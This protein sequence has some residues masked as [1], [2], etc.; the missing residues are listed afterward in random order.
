MTK[1]VVLLAGLCLS[2]SAVAGQC[3]I[4]VTASS[5]VNAKHVA[6]VQKWDEDTVVFR[7]STGNHLATVWVADPSMLN[8]YINK[9]VARIELC[10]E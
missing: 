7:S 3:M 8:A 10:G 2:T 4:K 1:L 6:S 9:M 5:Y